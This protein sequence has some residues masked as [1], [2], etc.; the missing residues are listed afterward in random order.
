MKTILHTPI[1]QN[2]VS[3]EE[4]IKYACSTP[5]GYVTLGSWL[6]VTS[7]IFLTKSDHNW[8]VHV[9]H[10]PFGLDYRCTYWFLGL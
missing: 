9:S 5:L 6:D 1:R 8:T 10:F 2:E 4:V 7:L 3:K